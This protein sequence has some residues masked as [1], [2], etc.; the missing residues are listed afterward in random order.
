MLNTLSA[1]FGAMA[2]VRQVKI[3]VVLIGNPAVGKTSLVRQFVLGQYDD[4]YIS[5]VGVKV[6]RK[7]VV[8]NDEEGCSNE[9]QMLVWDVLGQQDFKTLQR[10]SFQGAQAALVVCDVTRRDTLDAV[11]Y[12]INSLFDITGPVPVVLL[13]NKSDLEDKKAYWLPE[14]DEMAAKYGA[15]ALLT[16]AKT[17]DN[18]EKAFEL[19][20][21]GAC[22][23][24]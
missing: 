19:I 20:A 4:K 8:C 2:E 9:V 5:T 10:T 11:E 18:V 6:S 1:I 15:L 14:M 23:A 7:T 3:K 24:L 13:G 17:G 21:E 16:S 22:K 12:W